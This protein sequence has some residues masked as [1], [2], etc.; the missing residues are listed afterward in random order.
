MES[1]EIKK[2]EETVESIFNP[3]EEDLD[4]NSVDLEALE[5]IDLIQQ[6]EDMIYAIRIGDEE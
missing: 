2:L 5:G 1:G 6:L 3:G 4:D